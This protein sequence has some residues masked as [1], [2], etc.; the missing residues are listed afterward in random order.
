[1]RAATGRRFLIIAAL[2]A[3]AGCATQPTAPPDIVLRATDGSVWIDTEEVGR[4]R[5][6][7]GLLTCDDAVGRLSQRRCRCLE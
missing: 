2:A 7:R 1:M 5:C 6:E 4:F 3:T